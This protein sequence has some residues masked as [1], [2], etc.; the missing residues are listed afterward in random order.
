LAGNL[1]YKSADD[2]RAVAQWL[3]ENAILIETDAPYLAPVPFRGKRN[4]PKHV[5]ETFAVLTEIRK[6]TSES[7]A[8]QL[9]SNCRRIF[10]WPA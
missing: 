10:G 4:E 9:R 6:T 3:P 5:V 8:G 7:L 1:T 2:L